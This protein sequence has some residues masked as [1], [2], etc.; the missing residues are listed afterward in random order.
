MKK[1]GYRTTAACKLCQKA[2]E[3]CGGSW[4][5]ELQKE[6]ISHIQSV[7]CLGQKLV[8]TAAHNACIRELLQEVNAHG[9][10]DRHMKLL[11]IQTE[12]R[13][14]TLWDQKE[15]T[16]FCSKDE[17]SE[18]VKEEET[19]LPWREQGRKPLRHLGMSRGDERGV[20][21]RTCWRSDSRF[22]EMK[23]QEEPKPI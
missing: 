11:T 10:A 5:G 18:T 22:T 2:R 21:T 19:K 20:C 17:L 12:S 9:K 6:T 15:C 4:N 23:S 13:L 8:V 7:G 1:Y 14:G 16:Q 3:E